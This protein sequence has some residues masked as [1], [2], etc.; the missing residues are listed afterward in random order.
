MDSKD[1]AKT[2]FLP[3]WVAFERANSATRKPLRGDV[4]LTKVHTLLT[5]SAR[6]GQETGVALHYVADADGP[7][8]MKF[9]ST[10]DGTTLL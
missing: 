5:S 3:D 10:Y 6:I 7:A 1:F 4:P 8:R 9:A 2:Q